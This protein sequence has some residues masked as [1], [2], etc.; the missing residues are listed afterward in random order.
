M[1]A[2]GRSNAS[3]TQVCQGGEAFTL[4]APM[5]TVKGPRARF[6]QGEGSSFGQARPA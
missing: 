3:A 4:D 2:P 1:P 6:R 5:A